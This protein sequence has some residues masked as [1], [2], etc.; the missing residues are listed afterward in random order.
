M[1]SVKI[2][3]I[4]IFIKVNKIHKLSKEDNRGLFNLINEL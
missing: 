3:V 2:F 1:K 4:I